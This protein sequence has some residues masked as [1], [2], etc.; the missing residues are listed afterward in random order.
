M[1]EICQPFAQKILLALYKTGKVVYNFFMLIL[2][3]ASP[4]RKE[5]L[6][7]ITTEFKVVVSNFDEQ[8]TAL[9]PI[10]LAKYFAYEKARD[11]AK[12]FP[13]DVVIGCDTIVVFGDL[14][15]GKPK[16][17]KDAVDTLEKLSN[18]THFVYTAFSII[19]KNK[20]ICDVEQTKVLF[21]EL[22][23]KDVDDYVSS[24]S[25]F[26]KAGAYGIQDSDFV[27]KIEGSYS[28][29]MGFPKEKIELYLK[30]FDLIGE[31]L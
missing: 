5:L 30:Q 1:N 12:Q 9:A 17:H 2:A 8:P 4:R 20:E 28:N 11:V 25:P 23:K 6:A 10:E 13:D 29:V 3:S 22:S 16:T 19:S 21:R 14:V 7:E 31:N 18:N 26:D 15:L 27:I 24:G